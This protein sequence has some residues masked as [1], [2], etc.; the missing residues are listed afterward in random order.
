MIPPTPLLALA[1]LSLSL[2]PA[3]AQDFTDISLWANGPQAQSALPRGSHIGADGNFSIIPYSAPNCNTSS[4]ITYVSQLVYGA[5]IGFGPRSTQIQADPKT[6][7]TPITSL[8]VNRRTNASEWLELYAY[9]PA[10]NR[11]PTYFG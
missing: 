4:Q 2:P 6:M 3:R 5:L 1:A 10:G 9:T 11:D 7:Y 8:A